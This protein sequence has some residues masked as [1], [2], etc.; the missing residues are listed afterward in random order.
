[1]FT[2]L[3]AELG[4]VLSLT[5]DAQT[6]RLAVRARQV[7]PG[8]KLGDS[9]AVNGVCLTVVVLTGSSFTADVMPETL[10]SS[11]L[12]QL[13]PGSKVNLER[14]LR[15]ADGLDG[16]LVLG[17]VEGIGTIAGITREGNA[18]V[19]R[20]TAPADLLRYIIPKGSIAVDG[21]SLTV[22]TVTD[23]D[24]GVSLIPTTRK[25]TTLG[26]KGVGGQVNLETDI[27]AKYVERMLAA[28]LSQTAAAG[29]SR[30]TQVEN[31]GLTAEFLAKNGF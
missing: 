24:F 31:A 17:H 23:Q 3:V 4:T 6:C 26:E 21:I 12:G 1:M 29:G 8:L 9:I 25:S 27:L 19:F 13:K 28:R 30:R 18:E 2:G 10:R 11:N 7:L 14:T 22:T 5:E 20:I 15:P 16:H